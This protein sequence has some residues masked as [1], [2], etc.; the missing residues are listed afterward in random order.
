[1]P[2][3][4]H[5]KPIKIIAYAYKMKTRTIFFGKT[6]TIGF[7]RFLGSFTSL[8]FYVVWND[9][10]EIFRKLFFDSKQTLE[11]FSRTWIAMTEY[12]ESGS[13]FFLKKIHF[14]LTFSEKIYRPF[15]C[16]NR[17]SFSTWTMDTQD[18]PAILNAWMHLQHF[19]Y[20]MDCR[21]VDIFSISI[22]FET[23][24]YARWLF[25]RLLIFKIHDRIKRS[26]LYFSC[27]RKFSYN[28]TKYRSMCIHLFKYS[29]VPSSIRCYVFSSFYQWKLLNRFCSCPF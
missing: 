6:F 9:T 2:I 3:F 16:L 12:I 8:Q 27:N 18:I 20:Q 11:I 7:Y 10:F 25:L 17:I 28:R 14:Y 24:F 26:I 4:Y 21:C 19:K 15:C 23:C 1:M 13:I 22:W 5:S 29:E